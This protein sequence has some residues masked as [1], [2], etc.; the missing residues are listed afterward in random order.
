MHPFD[1]I[2]LFFSFIYTV[3]LTHILFAA[4]R[5]IRHRRQLVFSWAHA[6]WMGGVFLFLAVNWLSMWDLRTVA[7]FD[8]EVITS[9]FIVVIG[10]YFICALVAPDFEDGESYDLESFHRRER[11]TY[12]GAFIVMMVAG[13]VINFEGASRYGIA[14]WGQQN[15]LAIPMMA[16]ALAA[17]FIDRRWVQIGAPL[18]MIGLL[19]VDAVIYYPVLKSV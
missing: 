17:F 11:R 19:I 10:Q 1:F 5:M 8:L 6:L 4:T 14:A 12:Q 2:L 16:A 18:V 15:L 7:T 9:N 3:A 13:V